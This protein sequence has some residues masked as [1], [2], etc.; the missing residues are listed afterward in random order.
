[1]QEI[2]RWGADLIIAIQTFHNPI[3]DAFFNVV[4]SIGGE[5]FYLLLL[6]LLYWCVDKHLAQRLAYLFLL[7]AY[8]NA[9][10]KSLFAHPRPFE[11]D[12]RVLKLDGVPPQEL[13]YGLPSGHSQST[14]TVWGYLGARVRRRWMWVLA[15]ALLVLIPFSRI[16]LGVHFPTDVLGGLLVGAGWLAL[17][18]LLEPRLVRWLSRQ[19]IGVQVGLAVMLPVLLLLAYSSG[20]ATASMGALIGMGV[21]IAV[22]SRLVRFSAGGPLWQRVVR[23][24]VGV[25]V[26]V[27]LREGLKLVFPG[28]DEALYVLFRV[29]RYTL[30]GLW[31]TLIGPWAFQRL[32]LADSVESRV[33]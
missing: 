25:L 29:I 32:R 22:E 27:M 13:G 26:V 33:S 9:A 4:T 17:F 1:M 5:E 19:S 30:V 14:V 10:L 24:V 18:L 11:Y 3:L 8:S 7:S 28:E 12:P 15:T 23:F 21:G 2:W 20:D 31:A 16:Y 6:P